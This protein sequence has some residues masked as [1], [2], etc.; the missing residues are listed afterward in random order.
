MRVNKDGT[1]HWEAGTVVE[2]SVHDES[3]DPNLYYAR[4]L[5]SGTFPNLKVL[6]DKYPEVLEGK[7][8]G[9]LYAI[10]RELNEAEAQAI[11]GDADVSAGTYVVNPRPGGAVRVLDKRDGSLVDEFKTMEEAQEWIDA[12]ECPK[13]GRPKTTPAEGCTGPHFGG[14]DLAFT[15]F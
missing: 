15:A 9:C 14:E 1:A 5:T 11:T 12:H 10:W 2:I 8:Q 13:C 6:D 4:V 3:H 7:P